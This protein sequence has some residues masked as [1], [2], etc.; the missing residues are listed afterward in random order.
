MKK[1][2]GFCL[3]AL[4]VT[5]CSKKAEITAEKPQV[6]A[7]S[8]DYNSVFNEFIKQNDTLYVVNFWATWC[9]PC[10][11]ELPDF[12]KINKEFKDTNFKMI[13]VSLDKESDFETK[14]KDF[15]K[16]NTIL[17]DVYVLADN[18]RMNEWIPKISKHWS[19][20]IPATAIYKNGKQV[21]FTEGKITYND[22]KSTINK[23]K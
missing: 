23:L 12:M 18:K 6:I 15:L 19:G 3:F 8:N 2:I 10:V 11:E 5:S 21:Y 1:F 7:L 9:Q 4:I 22:L 14:V 17:P 13:L 20:A 16:T